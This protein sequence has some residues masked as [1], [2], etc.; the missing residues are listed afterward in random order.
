MNL[1]GFSSLHELVARLQSR[2]A[3]DAHP[4]IVPQE[5]RQWVFDFLWQMTIFTEARSDGRP[6][7]PFL[8]QLHKIADLPLAPSQSGLPHYAAAPGNGG[9]LWLRINSPRGS[10]PPWAGP[11]GERLDA[12]APEWLEGLRNGKYLL[13]LDFSHEGKAFDAQLGELH[14]DLHERGVPSTSVLLLSQ[15]TALHADCRSRL[16][17][18][19]EP[20]R[21]AYA[22]THAARYWA[23]IALEH[24]HEQRADLTIGF[25]VGPQERKY[26][27]L[28]MNYHLRPS[29]AIVVA[30]LLGR[31]EPGWLSF[32]AERFRTNQDTD[33]QAFLRQVRALSLTGETE[34]QALIEGGLHLETD[35]RD[36]KKAGDGV[37]RMPAEG[38][39]T[40][41]L[42]IVTETEMASPALMR[43]TEKT[44]KAIIAGIP[45]VVFG[46]YGTVRALREIGF[47]TLDDLVDHHYDEIADP[48]QRFAAAWAQVE[49][50]L[51]RPP[52]FTRHELDR[53]RAAA[54]HNGPVF[55]C[56]LPIFCILDPLVS[57]MEF[58]GNT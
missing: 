28:C 12:Q 1:S 41:E 4:R 26:R 20:V 2:G 44:L 33:R 31:P 55:E 3:A 25:A 30:R 15:N 50:F 37:Y 9:L 51:A 45:F 54:G 49:R 27:Y 52:G 38:F 57:I 36:F 21:A 14:R 48:A 8:A 29:R 22:H 40:S 35:T 19:T 42:Y 46:N 53:L 7:P 32:S 17:A 43:Y 16:V 23:M 39:A 56:R 34:V 6:P 24:N 5:V 11:L 13:V 58:C 18:G 10:L 47:D